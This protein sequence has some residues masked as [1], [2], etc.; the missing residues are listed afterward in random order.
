[1][2]T[3]RRRRLLEARLKK[4]LQKPKPPKTH[5]S[6]PSEW[7]SIPKAKAAALSGSLSCPPLG[8]ASV[9]GRLL[10]ELKCNT[11]NC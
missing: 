11:N 10:L 5:P 3:S 2:F 6:N 9:R 4:G 1:M 8:S 7:N